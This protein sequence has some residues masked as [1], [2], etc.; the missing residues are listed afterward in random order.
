MTVIHL[1]LLPP[2][3]RRAPAHPRVAHTLRLRVIRAG[4]A[5][6]A[7]RLVLIHAAEGDHGRKKNGDTLLLR[8]RGPATAHAHRRQ[9]LEE[10]VGVSPAGM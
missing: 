6:E 2:P 10:G 4:V 8:D 3:P 5:R 9:S 1:Q 7:F